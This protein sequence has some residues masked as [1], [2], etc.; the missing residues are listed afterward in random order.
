VAPVVHPPIPDGTVVIDGSRIHAVGPTSELRDRYGDIPERDLGSVVLTAGFVDTH[1]HVEWSMA[2]AGRPCSGGFAGWLAPM[3]T[4]RTAL[5]DD[6]FLACARWGV[7]QSLLS[8]STLILDAGPTGAAALAAHELGIRAH[9]HLE[10]FGR[11]AGEEATAEAQR[12]AARVVHLDRPRVRGGISPHAPYT[13]GPD[14]WRALAADP[15]LQGRP[16]MTHIAE[17]DQER[18]AIA[19]AA[20]PLADLFTRNGF[21]VATWPGTG[22]VVARLADHGALRHGLVAAH[23]VHLDAGDH[24]TL[25]DHHVAV[26]HCPV[27]NA[28]IGVGHHDLTRSAAAGLAVG[29]GSD[30]PATDGRFDLRAVLHAAVPRDPDSSLRWLTLDGARVAGRDDELGHL[31][32]AAHADC[33]AVQI[34]AGSQRPVDDLIDPAA[35]IHT[36]IVGGEIVVDDGR[37]T[38]ADRST[39]ETA[40]QEIQRRLM[41]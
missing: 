4:H 27:S 8:G 17:S 22:S 34:P 20:G 30:S 19:D 6:D 38:R 11:F 26:A 29:L 15:D 39:I 41:G 5:T 16:W 3:L 2:P 14:F 12:L 13:V 25:A 21:S 32:V 24:A 37:L 7:A 28:S 36:V 10:A 33:V 23:C 40:A 9:A 18:P 35:P 1:C 31:S